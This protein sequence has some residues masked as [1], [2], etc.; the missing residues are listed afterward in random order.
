M[1][2]WLATQRVL[3]LAILT[4]ALVGSAL[5]SSGKP[6]QSL[7]ARQ[8]AVRDAALIKDPATRSERLRAAIRAGLL[9]EA[10]DPLSPVFSYLVSNERWLNPLTYLDI[11]L[12]FDAVDHK[13]WHRALRF[14]DQ[15]ELAK[16]SRDRRI[17]V[18][19]AAIVEGEVRLPR[20]ERLVRA[21]AMGLAAVDGLTELESVIDAYYMQMDA[22]SRANY[23]LA[24][25]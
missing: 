9:A 20:G 25:C 12:E 6:V 23:P 7:T 16:A 22:Y 13:Q 15:A 11:L 3:L 8:Q 19:K 1:M 21:S 24:G 18:Y 5:A 17:E 14:L 10:G 4:S 2:K